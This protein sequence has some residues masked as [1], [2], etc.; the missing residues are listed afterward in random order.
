MRLATPLWTL[1]LIALGWMETARPLPAQMS[2]CPR[3][4]AAVD[5]SLTP[6]DGAPVVTALVSGALLEPS[7]DNQATGLASSYT[8]ALQCLAGAPET[9]RA[10]MPALQPGLWVHRVQVTDGPPRGQSQA[11][12]SLLLDASAGTHTLIW[13]LYAARLVDAASPASHPRTS[14]PSDVAASSA[15]PAAPAVPAV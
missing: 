3:S 15:A 5:V 8:R 4:G 12:R 14:A 7:C 1:A 10:A 11:R 6:V 9:C 2:A 13:P